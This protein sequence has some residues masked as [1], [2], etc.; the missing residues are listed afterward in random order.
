MLLTEADQLLFRF[1]HLCLQIDELTGEE[2]RG[3]VGR[4]VL[5]FKIHP[6]VLFCQCIRHFSRKPGVARLEAHINKSAVT[7][8]RGC[9]AAGEFVDQSDKLAFFEGRRILRFAALLAQS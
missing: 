6:D 4:V 1:F 8:G 5:G 3:G 2:I 9:Q 7:D